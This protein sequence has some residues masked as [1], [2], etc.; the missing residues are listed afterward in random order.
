VIGIGGGLAVLAAAAL[1]W[2]LNWG[3]AGVPALVLEKPAAISAQ[4]RDE[5]VVD[6][7]LTNLPEGVYPGAS[8]AVEFDRGKLEC[9]GVRQGT[10]KTLGGAGG[11]SIPIWSVDA[12]YANREGR[13]NAMYLDQTGE[14][15]AY[16]PD[17]FAKGDADIL[18]R[19]VF[20]LRD[21]A[22]AGDE[23]DLR[24]KDAVLATT[25]N[26]LRGSSLATADRT[27]RAFHTTVEVAD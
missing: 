10:M 15:W 8:L 27:L 14:T 1:I 5:I 3:P 13:V 22:Q 16:A 18:L 26:A 24:V 21:S 20:R 9:V 11:F 4:D 17:G 7:R 2:Y 25:D 12:D 19:L 6:V 23:L